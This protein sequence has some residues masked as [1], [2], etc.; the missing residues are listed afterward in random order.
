MMSAPDYVSQICKPNVIEFCESPTSVHRAWS[1][2]ISLYHY[3][4]YIVGQSE[5]KRFKSECPGFKLIRAVANAAKHARLDKTHGELS[6]MAASD[7][8]KIG[9]G[10]PFSDGTYYSDGT[11]HTDDL[12]VVRLEYKD[13]LID[14][15][16]LCQQAIRYIEIQAS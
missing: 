9:P 4:D 12:D 6:G 11:S 14:L 16:Q 10:A 1:A 2:L 8:A 3:K 15:R 7:V 13:E 5:Q